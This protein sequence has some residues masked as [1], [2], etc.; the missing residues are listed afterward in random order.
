M[1]PSHGGVG[2]GLSDPSDV[3]FEEVHPRTESDHGSRD[4]TEGLTLTLPFLN[5]V[6]MTKKMMMTFL[7]HMLMRELSGQDLL[8]LRTARG[9]R[10]L[11]VDQ[12]R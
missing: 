4:M 7:R 3:E 11:L 8:M 12:H 6:I 9:K 10:R 1:G 5:V 2:G